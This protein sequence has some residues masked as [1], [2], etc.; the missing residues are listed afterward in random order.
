MKKTEDSIRAR[1]DSIIAAARMLIGLTRV[2]EKSEGERAMNAELS[3]E[4]DLTGGG[5]ETWKIT[6]ERTASS[7]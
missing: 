1:S 7:H 2:A 6:I 4:V 3:L 5:C